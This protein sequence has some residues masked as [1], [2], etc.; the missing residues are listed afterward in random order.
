MQFGAATTLID[1]RGTLIV[2]FSYGA[3]RGDTPT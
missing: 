1:F 3:G 2:F